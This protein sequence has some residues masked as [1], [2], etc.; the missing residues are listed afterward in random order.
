MLLMSFVASFDWIRKWYTVLVAKPV[1]FN[2]CPV[3]NVLSS[4]ATVELAP[5]VTGVDVE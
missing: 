5:I 1:T 2:E 4:T 3:T